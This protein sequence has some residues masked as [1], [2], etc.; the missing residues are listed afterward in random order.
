MYNFSLELVG[1][2]LKHVRIDEHVHRHAL[3]PSI[4]SGRTAAS[5]H[6]LSEVLMALKKIFSK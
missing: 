1:M 2:L 6:A 5:V 3:P 4:N